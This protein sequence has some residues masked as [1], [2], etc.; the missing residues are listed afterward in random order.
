MIAD[1]PSHSPGTLPPAPP[2]FEPSDR[3]ARDAGTAREL[4]DRILQDGHRL[5]PIET[6]SLIT[7]AET[8][9]L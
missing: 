3:I 6:L 4:L 7:H 8:E 5:T 2:H 9:D 1:G